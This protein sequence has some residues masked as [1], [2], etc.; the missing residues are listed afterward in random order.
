MKIAIYGDSFADLNWNNNSYKGWPELLAESYNVTNFAKEGS[1]LWWSYDQLVQS[2]ANFDYNIFVGTIY[3]RIYIE[4]LKTHLSVNSNSW[5]IL[6][7]KINLGYMYYQHF[8]SHR[9]DYQLCQLMIKDIMS[10]DNTL[11]IPAFEESVPAQNPKLCSLN[12]FTGL[13]EQH[14]NIKQYSSDLRKCH[15]TKENNLI[16]YNKIVDAI[17]S[18]SK[19]LNLDK[20]DFNAPMDSMDYYF[21]K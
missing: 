18:K 7:G 1:S 21:T 11:Y 5:P 3:S 17:S 19:T 2:H 14:Y 15:L 12:A 13:E 4:D 10:L 20:S 8:F 9:R 16:V 6:D